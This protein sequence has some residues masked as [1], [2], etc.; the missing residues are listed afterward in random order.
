[1][2]DNQELRLSDEFLWQWFKMPDPKEQENF[3]YA[4]TPYTCREEYEK[5]RDGLSQM[6]NAA[7]PQT[8]FLMIHAA[9]VERTDLKIIHFIPDDVARSNSEY[10]HKME[11]D[12]EFRKASFAKANLKY[13][14]EK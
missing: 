3:S 11:T 9:K 8:K 13:K 12:E 2:T 4:I 7:N 1:M 10:L 6:N 5:D 14:W